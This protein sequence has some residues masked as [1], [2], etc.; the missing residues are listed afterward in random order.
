[1]KILL[2][3]TTEGLKPMYDR[4]Y[5]EKR[6]L[7]LGK[8]Y[9][10]NIKQVRNLEFHNK[11]FKLIDV[12]WEI[13]GERTQDFFKTKENFRKSVQMLA[14]HYSLIFSIKRNEW[15]EEPK[16]VSFDKLEQSEFEELY[17]RV[18][19]VIWQLM[20]ERNLTTKENFER[21]INF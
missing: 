2:Y 7:K 13:F 15:I 6:K 17:E 10:A 3:N 11:Y 16:S 1:M 20:E 18:K 8:V 19:D 4:D 21:L 12:S 9:E 5:E 14:G